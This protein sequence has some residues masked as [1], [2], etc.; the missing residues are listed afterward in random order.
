MPCPSSNIT[1]PIIGFG[2][3][4]AVSQVACGSV[5]D[6]TTST[7]DVLAMLDDSTKVV[8]N[9]DDSVSDQPSDLLF[10]TDAVVAAEFGITEFYLARVGVDWMLE[11]DFSLGLQLDVGGVTRSGR[12]ST[13]LVGIAPIMRWRFLER[14]A[15]SLYA[16][17]GVGVAWTGE[18]VPAAGT[19]FNFTP[20]A[21]I[22]VQFDVGASCTA[23]L[24]LGW[25]H[26]S[27]ARTGSNNPGLDAVSVS[28]GLAWAF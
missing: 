14:D 9:R 27:N 1:L 13:W 8:S 3:A 22:G 25:Y 17:L 18:P 6:A 15:W 19:S 2:A 7:P 23:R 16:D 5:D 26:M 10:R 21:G 4:F 20:Q 11:R 12:S 24:G 28:A